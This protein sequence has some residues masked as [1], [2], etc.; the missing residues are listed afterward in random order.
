M[1]STF[2]AGLLAAPAAMSL[3]S[4]AGV[5]WTV[6]P[7]SQVPADWAAIAS[8][9]CP[10][11]VPGE[12]HV[13]LLTAGLIPDPFDGDNESMLAWIGRTN[14]IYRATFEWGGSDHALRLSFSRLPA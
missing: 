1:S 13:D 14:W 3:D 2:R 5:W 10:A 11:T 4:S 8:Q 9:A 7:A 12:V 6:E